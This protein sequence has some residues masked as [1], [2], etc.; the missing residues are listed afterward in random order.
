MVLVYQHPGTSARVAIFLGIVLAS[1]I[2]GAA[3]LL[4]GRLAR[5]IPSSLLLFL[6]QVLCRCPPSPCS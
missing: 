1:L 4:A 3:L 5:W 6:T 2:V